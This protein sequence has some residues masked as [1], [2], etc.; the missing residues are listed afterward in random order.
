M[1]LENRSACRRLKDTPAQAGLGAGARRSNLAGAF[2]PGR[3]A[4]R[5]KGRD[6]L[7]MDDVLTTGATASAVAAVLLGAG[8]ARVGVWT[9][10][11]AL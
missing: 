3:G 10:A 6:C 1:P 5:V 9:L 4:R 7:V 2:G 11:R 8:A